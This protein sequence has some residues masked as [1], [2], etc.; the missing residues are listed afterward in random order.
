LIELLGTD[1]AKFGEPMSE[2]TTFRVGGPA[3]LYLMPQD[4]EAAAKALSLCKAH[5]VP[6]LVLGNGSNLLV[7]DGGIRGVVMQFGSQFNAID[8]QGTS[9]HA[10]AGALLSAVAAEACRSG[11]AGME[12]ASGIPGTVGGATAMNAGAYG[13]EMKDIVQSVTA[14]TDA[15]ELQAFTHDEMEFSYRHS[16]ASDNALTIVEVELGLSPGDTVRSQA[17]TCEY[18]AARRQKQPLEF[19]SAG[20]FFKRPQGNYASKLIQEAGLKGTRVGGAMV[21]EKHSGFIVNMGG[22]TADDVLGLATVVIERVKEYSGVTLEL[23]VKVVGENAC[24]KED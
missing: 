5:G 20:S 4:A 6:L 9:I 1:R 19:P 24:R 7:R 16:R 21:S 23:E 18:T 13:G 10:Q 15:G 3:D 8:V 22:A 11:L 2:H 14:I 12:W 17:L